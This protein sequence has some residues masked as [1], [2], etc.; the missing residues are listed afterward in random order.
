MSRRSLSGKR[1][2]DHAPVS[3]HENRLELLERLTELG[4]KNT[5]IV[6][7]QKLF[8]DTE[9]NVGVP[10]RRNLGNGR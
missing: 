10:R 4:I 3:S 9:D 5:S 2:D 1:R 8:K 6:A 7:L